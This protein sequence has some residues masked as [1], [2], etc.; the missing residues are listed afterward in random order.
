MSAVA[1]DFRYALRHLRRSPAFAVGA[2]LPLALGISAVAT[3]CTLGYALLLRPLPVEEPDTLVVVAATRNHGRDLGYVSYP[4]YRTF[5]ERSTTV[6]ELAAHYATAP[7]WV[8]NNRQGREINGA[9]VTANYF[10]VLRLR[11]ALG[12]FFRPEEDLVPDRDRVAVLSHRTWLESFAG[13]N[14]VLGTDVHINGV[15]FTVVGVAPPHWRGLSVQPAEIYIPLMAIRAGYRWC[16]VLMD[17][18][19]TVLQM[20]GRLGPGRTVDD[21]RAEIATLMP[22]GWTDAPERANSGTTVFHPRGAHQR[23]T[24]EHRRPVML[25]AL[26]A[27]VL[28]VVCCVNVAGLLAIRSLGRARELAVRASLGASRQQLARLVSAE[29]LVLGLA[30]GAGGLLLSAGVVRIVNAAFYAF[31]YAGRPLHIDFDLDVRVAG[32]VLVTT[33]LAAMMAGLVPALRSADAGMQTALRADALAVG[34]SRWTHALLAIQAACAIGLAVVAALLLE[35]AQAGEGHERLDA[36]R[37]VVMRLRPRLLEYPPLKAQAFLRAVLHRLDAHP[38]VE[39]V[40]PTAVGGVLDGLE[41]DVAVDGVDKWRVGYGEVG[42]RY[43]ET[44]RIPLLA[45]REFGRF[46]SEATPPVVIVNDTLARRIQSDGRVVDRALQVN[47]R[48]HRIV[49]VVADAR[50]TNRTDGPR[51]H[52]YT[53]FW[54]N[55]GQVDARLAIRVKG[56]PERALPLLSRA[57]S[58]VDPDVP[59]SEIVTLPSQIERLTLKPVRLAGSIVGYAAVLAVVVSALGLY[60][61]L[62]FAVTRRTRELAVRVALG[63]S[64]STIRRFVLRDAVRVLLVG[65]VGGV[66]LSRAATPM[67]ADLLYVPASHDTV[68]LAISALGVCAVGLAAAW[69]PA[70]RAA[71]I[72][73]SVALRSE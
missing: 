27:G 45:G 63:A 35:S 42:P 26:A 24:G 8:V 28:M 7:L 71:S 43:F 19:C 50:L 58:A 1:H 11:P 49:G 12:R 56:L 34:R 17:P 6:S 64:P 38:A 44:L 62:A 39:S 47:G 52:A 33:L 53:P 15:A 22:A 41:R 30:G 14:D 66:A 61:T 54:Q 65:L 32:A 51:P 55:P 67:L 48:E 37:V 16:D 3:V 13:S 69:F 57:V 2:I 23:P 36:S 72:M 25:L 60:A 4:D 70:R 5:Q 46:D 73:P 20:V 21:A 31:D 40:S 68:L 18:E 10:Q 9:V 59:V 29:T